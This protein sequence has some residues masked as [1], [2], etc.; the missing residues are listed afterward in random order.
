MRHLAFASNRPAV[1]VVRRAAHFTH[2]DTARVIPFHN[3]QAVRAAVFDDADDAGTIAIVGVI[4]RGG[5]RPGKTL[6]LDTWR[7]LAW[8]ASRSRRAL[9]QAH[10]RQVDVRRCELT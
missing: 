5:F 9:R 1:R 8:L 2:L 6:S 7:I 4:M 10:M 3:I